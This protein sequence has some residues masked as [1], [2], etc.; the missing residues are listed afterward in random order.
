[1]AV[2]VSIFDPDIIQA[3]LDRDLPGGLRLLADAVGSCAMS[4]RCIRAEGIGSNG[5]D[6][7]VLVR[8]VFSAPVRTVRRVQKV[9]ELG[10]GGLDQG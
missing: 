8:L 10:D 7:S 9:A 2:E 6:A 4:G 3:M 1:M 5:C